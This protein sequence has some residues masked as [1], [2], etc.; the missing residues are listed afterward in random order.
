VER[1]LAEC[2]RQSH[3]L[4]PQHLDMPTALDL[5]EVIVVHLLF[6]GLRE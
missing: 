5:D 3:T 6:A 4:F 2:D 1:D